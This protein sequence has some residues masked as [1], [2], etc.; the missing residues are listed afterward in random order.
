M[1]APVLT[2]LE[3]P[4]PLLA[5][6]VMFLVEHGL[7]DPNAKFELMDGAIIPM[8]PKGRLHEAMRE[9]IMDWL[10]ERWAADFRLTL[11]HTLVLDEDTIVEP[12]FLLYQKTRSIADAP[13]TGADIT[14]VIE[15][16]DSSWDYDTKEKAAKYAAFGVAEYWVI[17]A[18]RRITRMH[19]APTTGGWNEVQEIAADQ[20]LT[21]ICAPTATF[22]A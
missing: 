3:P 13:L 19:R 21:P 10:R 11:E 8:S 14:L 17:D 15:V 12:D 6:D 5:S 4:R 22:K 7:I 9:R 16:A 20:P 18:S 2:P 1:N